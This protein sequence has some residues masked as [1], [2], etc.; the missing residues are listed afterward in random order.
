MAK[1]VTLTW[2]APAS[3]E[4]PDRYNIYRKGTAGVTSGATN[5]PFGV[6][7]V[8]TTGAAV[9]GI[10]TFEETHAGAPSA[11]HTYEDTTA[12]DNALVHYCVTAVKGSEESDYAECVVGADDSDGQVFSI[13]TAA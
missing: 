8:N 10:T 6:N 4:M 5:T 1:T 3:G 2:K 13:T 12:P 7:G 11:V 9:G